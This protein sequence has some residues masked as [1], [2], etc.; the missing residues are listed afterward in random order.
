MKINLER[1]FCVCT[2]I[3]C[4]FTANAGVYSFKVSNLDNLKELTLKWNLDGTKDVVRLVNGEGSIKND[5]FEPQ[6]VTLIYG[7]NNRTVYLEPNKDLN[8]V[9]DGKS[10][11]NPIVFNGKNADINIY[12]NESRFAFM[13][14]GDCKKTESDFI[15]K[16]DSVYN[17]NIL[18]LEKAKL[19]ESF[20]KIEKE[21]IK[22]IAYSL[23]TIFPKYHKLYNKLPRFSPTEVYY[24]KLEEALQFD[25]DLLTIPEYKQFISQAI[26]MV[27]YHKNKENLDSSFMSFIESDVKDHKVA[28]Y[29]T[30]TYIYDKISNYGI[31][32]KGKLIDFYHKYVKYAD[33]VKAFDEVCNKWSAI[34]TGKPSPTFTCTDI[35][36]KTVSLSD[37]KG[38]Y[39]Y[40]DVWATW[41]APCR[42]EL[43]S[44]KKIEE[45]YSKKGIEFVS[46]SGDKNKSAWEKM[47]RKENMKGIQLYMGPKDVFM[48]QYIINSIPRFILLDREGCIL[49][50]NA[51]RP[52]SPALVE[53]FDELVSQ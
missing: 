52:S 14:Y 25:S 8:I 41:C 53:L 49:K 38:K 7:R 2:C 10:V 19:E 3:V 39:V 22:Y 5:N 21:R 28:E 17:K 44:L 40:I 16:I 35:D 47:V 33:R 24:N 1:I 18:L 26:I 13:T 31:E 50:A 43:P 29:L 30:D 27:L 11:K 6:Y 51:P 4:S 20:S 36:G 46:I 34:Q 9:I 45:I 12:L 42:A 23:L 32:N 48:K 37:L 15:Q